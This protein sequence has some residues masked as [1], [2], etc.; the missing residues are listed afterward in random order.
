MPMLSRFSW[1]PA[2]TVAND[3]CVDSYGVT[4]THDAF[5]KKLK[6]HCTPSAAM[7]QPVRRWCSFTIQFILVGSSAAIPQ[8]QRRWCSSTSQSALCVT[9]CLPEPHSIFS[10]RFIVEQT[11]RVL[12]SSVLPS[13]LDLI[14]APLQRPER[15]RPE[16][17]LFVD[18]ND[19]CV[20]VY[21][22]TF[23]RDDFEK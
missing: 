7:P 8:A 4:L 1:C 21:V 15:L 6:V 12:A 3:G 18:A 9:Y 17:W 11:T 2:T 5:E 19:G 22:A 13:V 20:A 10:V 23:T 16:R 14:S